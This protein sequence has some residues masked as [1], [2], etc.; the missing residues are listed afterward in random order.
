MSKELGERLQRYGADGPVRI[1]VDIACE[2]GLLASCNAEAVV[3]PDTDREIL[4]TAH[5]DPHDTA[6]GAK[7]NGVRC[8]LVVELG[9]LLVEAEDCLDTRV[10]LATF[11]AEELALNGSCHYEATHD[12]DAVECVVNI[13]GAG[14]SRTPEIRPYGFDGVRAVSE[15]VADSFGSSFAV[16]EDFFPYTDAWPFVEAGIPAVTAGST[17]DG[18]GRGWANTHVG[19]LDKLDRRD[20]RALAAIYLGAVL[21]LA[22]DGT[23][24]TRRLPESARRLIEES[25]E[26]S[27]RVAGLWSE[28]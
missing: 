19:T 25:G 26:R 20:L 9:R 14:A 13:D 23:E 21:E 16:D 18:S 3:G 17:S 28:T 1:D 11:G 8:A 10:R 4:V 2:N 27:L 12:L 15:R 6:E 24:L 7:D 5:H 22:A